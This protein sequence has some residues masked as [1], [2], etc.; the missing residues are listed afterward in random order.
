MLSFKDFIPVQYTAGETEQQDLNAFK[1][2]RRDVTETI[3][4]NFA[5]NQAQTDIRVEE[6]KPSKD[7]Q[8]LSKI[9]G[10]LKK[11]PMVKISVVKP[12]GYRIA[13]IGPGGMEHNVQTG[14]V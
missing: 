3:R 6:V 9:R 2:K 13:D 10:R 7:P 14:T 1:R 12:V 11:R 5:E 8:T 4:K